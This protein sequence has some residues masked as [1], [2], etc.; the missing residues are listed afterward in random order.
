[1]INEIK[2]KLEDSTIIE[3]GHYSY[4]YGPNELDLFLWNLGVELFVLAKKKYNEI[5]LMV[6][7]DDVYQV[8]SNSER[9]N[10]NINILPE[11]YIQV[12]KKHKISEKEVLKFSQERMKEKGRKLISK[13]GLSRTATPVCRLIVATSLRQK[14]KEGYKNTI[15][16]SDE[17]KTDKGFN[18]LGGTTFSR[19]LYNTKIKVHQFVFKNKKKYNYYF[20]TSETCNSSVKETGTKNCN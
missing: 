3:A 20:M 11:K 17:L 2:E 5:A 4:K 19:I 7:V 16:L 15:V 12:L 1:M 14:E 8:K 10:F 6:L 18:M 13:M 9:R